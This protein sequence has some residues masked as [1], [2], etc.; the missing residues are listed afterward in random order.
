M[1]KIIALT[2]SLLLCFSS[3]SAIAD[4]N[5]ATILDLPGK[6]QTFLYACMLYNVPV[7]GQGF[8]NIDADKVRSDYYYDYE[9]LSIRYYKETDNT[10]T[11]NLIIEDKYK[12]WSYIL[13]MQHICEVSFEEAAKAYCDLC[14]LQGTPGPWKQQLNGTTLVLNKLALSI[15]D[16]RN[17]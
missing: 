13:A 3:L 6:M 1:K 14:T 4:S 2:L 17:G 8:F 9:A 10:Y 15:K 7:Y 11:F 5:K 12:P 16:I